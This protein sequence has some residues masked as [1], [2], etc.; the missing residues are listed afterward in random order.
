MKPYRGLAI[1]FG[2][3][4]LGEGISQTLNLSVPGSVIGMLLLLGALLTGVIR[5]SW[6][7]GEAEFF[8]KNMSVMFIPPGVGVITYLGLIRSQAVPIFTAL[9]VSFALTLIVTA[10]TVEFMRRAET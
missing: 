5:L 6:V 8:V 3:Y 4:A 9:V 10:K 2:F 7:E 1:V